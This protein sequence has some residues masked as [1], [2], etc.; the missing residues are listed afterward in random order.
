MK[1]IDNLLTKQ[2]NGEVLDQQQL[3]CLDSLSSV[4]KEM[5][6][7]S[8][9]AQ[10]SRRRSRSRDAEEEQKEEEEEEEVEE[11]EEEEE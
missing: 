11:E 5:E 9:P 4:V 10:A 1:K 3:A 7:Y 8:T 6:K 2:K